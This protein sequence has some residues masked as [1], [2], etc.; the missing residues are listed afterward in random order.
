MYWSDL[1]VWKKS[2]GLVKE[3][4]NLGSGQERQNIEVVKS[5]L[6][7]LKVDESRIEF[8]K[9][10]PGHDVRYKLNSQKIPQEVGWQAKVKFEEG[11][12][13]TVEWCVVHKDWLLGKWQ[14]IAL[15]YKK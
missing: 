13:K 8:V 4:Y 1:N 12:Q 10:R 14:K 15:L 6:A 11:I 5:I 2:H 3:I 9:D 7:I